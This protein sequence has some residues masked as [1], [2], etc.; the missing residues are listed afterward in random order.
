M[1]EQEMME[2][3]GR[4]A[5]ALQGYVDDHSP[6]W[7][8]TRGALNDAYALFP[9]RPDRKEMFG[10][11]SVDDLGVPYSQRFRRWIDD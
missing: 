5:Y 4:L 7:E 1:S 3:I 9:C 2:L 8:V 10:A 6:R 11:I